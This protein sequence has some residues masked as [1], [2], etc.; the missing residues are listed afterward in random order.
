[1]PA[2]NTPSRAK[3]VNMHYT[4]E[5]SPINDVA[6]IAVHRQYRIMMTIED[7]D[8]KDFTAQLPILS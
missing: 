4:Y 2:T 5:V 7:D 3:D 6:R 1:M 8:D